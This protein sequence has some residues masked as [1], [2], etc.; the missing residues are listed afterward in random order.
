MKKYLLVFI[1][2]CTNFFFQGLF[3]QQGLAIIEKNVNIDARGLFHNLNTTK[4]TLLLKSDKKID[5]VYSINRNYKRE[6]DNYVDSKSYKVPLNNLS[7]GKHVFVVR[8]SPVLI[9]FVNRIF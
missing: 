6:V 2:T 3:A 5:Y 4:D 9:V 1:T 7:K 8:Q